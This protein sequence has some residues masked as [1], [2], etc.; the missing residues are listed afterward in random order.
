M[1]GSITRRPCREGFFFFL[2]FLIFHMMNICVG[3]A[4]A[5]WNLTIPCRD[6][7]PCSCLRH[8]FAGACS[9]FFSR[10]CSVY[11]SLGILEKRKMLAG[12]KRN[13]YLDLVRKGHPT[14]NNKMLPSRPRLRIHHARMSRVLFRCSAQPHKMELLCLSISEFRRRI[15]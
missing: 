1:C 7:G 13:E 11:N 6:F 8:L 14:S 4:S 15:R 10:V 12:E 5:A 3:A 9:S 2:F